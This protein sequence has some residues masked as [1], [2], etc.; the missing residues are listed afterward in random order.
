M[1]YDLCIFDLDGTLTDPRLGITRAYQYALA[2]FGIKEDL[3][4]KRGFIG[5]PLR[6]VFTNVY[7]FSGADTEKAVAAFRE[8]YSE[9]GLLENSVYPGIHEMLQELVDGGKT[10]A[11]ATNKLKSYTIDIL[12]NFDLEKFFVFV[13][14]DDIDGTLSRHGKKDIIKL[15]IDTVGPELR[16]PTVMIGDRK[17]DMLGARDLG[18]YSIGVSWGYGSREELMEAGA[19]HIVDSPG[20]LRRW[21]TGEA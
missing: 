2:A 1:S 14:G 21:I 8:Y 12:K 20:Q 17:H 4:E 5:P 7:G 16:M 19:M 10:L 18:I 6:E 13:S 15:V 11:I 3:S 9:K